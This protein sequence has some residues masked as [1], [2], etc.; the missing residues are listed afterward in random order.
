VEDD[1]DVMT[2]QPARPALRLLPGQA[3]CMAASCCSY[4]TWRFVS[5]HASVA[6][7]AS[8]VWTH[9]LVGA[10]LVVRGG[11]LSCEAETGSSSGKLVGGATNWLRIGRLASEGLDEDLRPT[12]P[13]RRWS[14]R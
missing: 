11:D 9:A 8:C 4:V 10:E 7:L 12:L 3:A 2:V 5:P 13:P 6:M 14:S 1:D